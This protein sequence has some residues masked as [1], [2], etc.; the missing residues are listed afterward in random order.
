MNVD[1][2]HQ[3]QTAGGALLVGVIIGMMYEG[4]R[5]LRHFRSGAVMQFICDF[6]LIVGAAVVSVQY[7]RYTSDGQIRWFCVLS[8]L[9]GLILYC[10]LVGRFLFAPICRLSAKIGKLLR[11][12]VFPFVWVM[13]LLGKTLNLAVKFAEKKLKKCFIFIKKYSIINK[14]KASERK[15]KERNET[16]GKEDRTQEYGTR[17]YH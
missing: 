6:V 5:I 11:W 1:T 2:L 9:L 15:T 17:F 14:S 16:N 8:Q 12:M 10:R 3:L 4:L 7:Y 13:R